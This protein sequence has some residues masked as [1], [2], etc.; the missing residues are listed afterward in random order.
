VAW[1]V[2][3]WA[4]R[5]G[6]EMP[7]VPDAGNFAQPSLSLSRLFERIGWA[8]VL[9]YAGFDLSDS[10]APIGPGGSLSPP[11]LCSSSVE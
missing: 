5:Y 4:D 8:A 10:R 6:P 9:G 3:R 2:A 1:L 7:E 11:A